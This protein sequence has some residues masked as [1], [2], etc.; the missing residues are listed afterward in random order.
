MTKAARYRGRV[1]YWLQDRVLRGLIVGLQV[2]PYH[3][4]VPLCGWVM[5]RVL[6]PFTLYLHRIRDNLLLIYPS[7][8]KPEMRRIQFAVLNNFGR[9]LIEIYSGDEFTSRSDRWTFTGDGLAALDAAHGEGRPVLLGTAHFGNYDAVRAKLINRGYRLGAVYRATNNP[10]FQ[11][12]YIKAISKIGTPL[13]PNTL[14]GSRGVVEFLLSGNMIGILNDQHSGKGALLPFM[15]RPAKTALS[16]ARLAIKYDALM[17]PVYGIR[18]A[19][20][21]DFEI[22]VEA[23]IPHSTAEEM[24]QKFNDNLARLVR[25]HPGQWLWIHRRWKS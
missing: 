3:W 4:R 11:A 10:F 9:T 2:L 25:A 5:A 19:N 22:V 18:A 21:L 13:F 20:G 24:T 7:L 14:A 16:M 15:G 17:V 8:S 23:P 12:H 6:S 1:F